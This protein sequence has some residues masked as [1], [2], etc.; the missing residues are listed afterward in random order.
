MI[1]VNGEPV[2]VRS[3][4]DGTSFIKIARSVS[5]HIESPVMVAWYYEGEQEIRMVVLSDNKQGIDLSIDIG[6]LLD[7]IK[8]SPFVP[9]VLGF[10]LLKGLKE[11]CKK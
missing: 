7:E 10:F 5:D 9:P 4:S 6:K 11:W 8:I 1:K 2:E 3:F